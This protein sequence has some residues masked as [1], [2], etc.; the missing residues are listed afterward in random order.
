MSRC[1]NCFEDYD[2]SL[3]V[4]PYCGYVEGSSAKE[5]YQLHPGVIIGER[6]QIG[7]AVG[8]G[9]FG[10][11]Y[12]A[13]DL[14]LDALVAIKEYYP[15]GIVNRIPGNKDVIIFSGKRK[16]DFE[17]GRV[18]FLD[19]AKNMA[20]FASNR[21]I[22]HVFDYFEENNTAY[23]VME[24]LDGVALNVFLH[25]NGEKM[26][27]QTGIRIA[28]SV[29]EA[30]RDIH[31][32]G[33]VH[34]DISP[35]NIF[36]C[37]NNT[38]KLID[39]GAARFSL[40]ED[41]KMTVILKPGFAPPEQYESVNDQGPWTDI[42]ALGA[43]LYLIL[44]GVKPSESTNRKINDDVKYP[45]EL[46]PSI[47]I[48]I[49]NAIMKAMA[50][51]RHMR[52]NNIDDFLNALG[53]NKKVIPV[54]Q[55]RKKRKKKRF[56]GIFSAIL[57]VILSFGFALSY[58]MTQ[59]K[60]EA[61][62]EAEIT[63]WVMETNSN[64]EAFA[65]IVQNFETA[66]DTV[67]VNVKAIP[68]SE[69]AKAIDEALKSGNMPD[70]FE[71]T[72]LNDSELESCVNIYPILSRVNSELMIA[73]IDKNSKRLPIGFKTAVAYANT[74]IAKVDNGSV[75][76]SDSPLVSIG[77]IDKSNYDT[78][79][80]SNNLGSNFAE[81]TDFYNGK[82]GVLLSDS[83]DYFDVQSKLS[84]HYEILKATN[85]NDKISANYTMY[86]SVFGNNKDQQ[87]IAERLLWYLY[88]DSAQDIIFL[89]NKGNGLPVNIAELGIYKSTFSDFEYAISTKITDYEM[90]EETK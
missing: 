67:T 56:A 42:Y 90:K 37:I 34:R 14:K 29:G 70:L 53:G 83:N 7:M 89:Q 13:W 16:N 74:S 9:G 15:A 32:N 31:K 65:S 43:T 24:F 21:N 57:A 17:F 88:G 54:E 8:V 51:D 85:G 26:D 19:E 23:I 35:D 40:N 39:F 41:R 27:L 82:T 61:L 46:E 20:R 38:I 30:L 45:H 64:E 73:D 12:K 87:K 63:V 33:I 48:N 78:F 49:S 68:N 72:V 36:I 25:E 69:Y 3:G 6:Y 84:G 50:I 10:I 81:K 22:V 71:S 75:K 60:E 55:E 79:I 80:K 47:P 86:F 28:V 52:F 5:A 59:K 2:E 4:C 77:S 62:P 58:W 44:T 11:T 66:Y 18:R 1:K 76:F